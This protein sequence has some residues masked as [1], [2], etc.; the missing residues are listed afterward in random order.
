LKYD[1]AR[2]LVFY[3]L[4]Y[5]NKIPLPNPRFSLYKSHH[6]PSLLL[7]KRKHTGVPFLSGQQGVGLE[8]KLTALSSYH[9]HRHHMYLRRTMWDGSQLCRCLGL[10][11]GFS[12]AGDT[13]HIHMRLEGRDG[14]RLEDQDRMRA[15]LIPLTLRGY[16][17]L[18]IHDNL[19]RTV[20]S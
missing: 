4:G 15:S 8:T 20:G 13:P 9:P 5:T 10:H 17:H 6:L 7:N 16:H 1:D 12:L 2:N 14:T 3:F 19:L 18:S 11:L